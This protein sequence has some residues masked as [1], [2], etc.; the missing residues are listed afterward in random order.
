M[1]AGD[2]VPDLTLSAMTMRGRPFADRVAAVAAAGYTG[3]GLTADDYRHA[4]AAGLTAR[5]EALTGRLAFRQV[6]GR[7]WGRWLAA[8]AAVLI[9]FLDGGVARGWRRL[10]VLLYPYLVISLR[11]EPDRR[12]L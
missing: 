11:R 2:A 1:N 5:L 9:R 10:P 7:W 8:P 4:V 6:S 3:I 12:L